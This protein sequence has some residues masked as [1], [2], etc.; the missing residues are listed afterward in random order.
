MAIEKLEIISVFYD[1]GPY[2]SIIRIVIG[3]YPYMGPRNEEQWV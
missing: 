1:N 2:R 3:L